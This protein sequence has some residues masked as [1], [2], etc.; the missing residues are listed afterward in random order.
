MTAGAWSRRA[1]RHLAYLLVTLP[2]GMAYMFYLSLAM[3]FGAATAVF[4]VGVPLLL[5]VVASC[6]P[7]AEFER[8]LAN[9]LLDARVPAPSSDDGSRRLPRR[10]AAAGSLWERAVA[11]LVDSRSWFSLLWVAS[12]GL[13]GFVGTVVLPVYVFVAGLCLLAPFRPGSLTLEQVGWQN[14]A[15]W[16]S[17]WLVVVGVALLAILL[18]IAD[19][20]ARAHAVLARLV[21]GTR[22]QQA[23]E[24]I[25][26]LQRREAVLVERTRLARELH[27]SVGHTLTVGV[28]QATAAGQVLDTDPAF[29][30]EA[31]SSIEQ[32]GRRALD[33]LDAMLDVLRDEPPGHTA[34]VGVAGLTELVVRFRKV[35]LPVEASLSGDLAAVPAPLGREVYRIVQEGCTNVLRHAGAVATTVTVTVTEA[36]VTVRVENAA[37]SR[38]SGPPPRD[39]DGGNGLR[40]IAERV[41]ALGGTVDIQAAA[42]GGF[43]LAAHLPSPR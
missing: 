8:R 31:L 5:L 3:A 9:W 32:I 4:V 21:L 34:D 10:Q 6:R 20:N 40:G 28:V 38:D 11:V 25:R 33:E 27:D 41:H 37:G 26:A 15:G 36:T 30:R 12:R 19:L 24:R 14:A 29:V 35:G 13:E 43:R 1:L 17:A 39:R 22:A 7:I 42:D 2:L 18:P 23:Q 16:S